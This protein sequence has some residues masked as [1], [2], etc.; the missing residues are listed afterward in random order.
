MKGLYATTTAGRKPAG[1]NYCI[2]FYYFSPSNFVSSLGKMRVQ[3][4]CYLLPRRVHQPDEKFASSR[5]A[6]APCYRV[7]YSSVLFIRFNEICIIEFVVFF[8]ALLFVLF[9]AFLRVLIKPTKCVREENSRSGAIGY[10]FLVVSS[11]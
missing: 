4:N 6:P 11:R 2:S 10:K 3:N 8:F 5:L 9:V 7:T 1:C